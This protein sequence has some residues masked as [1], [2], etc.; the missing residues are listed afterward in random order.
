ML[1]ASLPL[2]HAAEPE[3]VAEEQSAAAEEMAEGKKVAAG[4]DAI[5][6]KNPNR[7]VCRRVKPTGS[8]I[9]QRVCLKQRDWDAMKRDAQEAMRERSSTDSMEHE[10]Q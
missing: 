1:V 6:A 9:G 4:Y 5:E 10:R 3:V 7:R 8:H 2:A